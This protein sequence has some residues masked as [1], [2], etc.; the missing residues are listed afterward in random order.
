MALDLLLLGNRKPVPFSVEGIRIKVDL[1]LD[2]VD[3]I[4]LHNTAGPGVDHQIALLIDGQ[5]PDFVLDADPVVA[6]ECLP[7]WGHVD[8][9]E[10]RILIERVVSHYVPTYYYYIHC[11]SISKQNK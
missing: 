11:A 3:I 5:V 9:E 8:E 2:S 1:H 4:Q 7:L 6:I 10:T